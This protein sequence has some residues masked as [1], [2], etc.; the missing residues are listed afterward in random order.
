MTALWI[1]AV[2]VAGGLGFFT[3]GLLT[4]GK[5]EDAYR[6]G[7]RDAIDEQLRRAFSEIDS[8]GGTDD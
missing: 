2:I 8:F 4:S 7:R 6:A 3:A 1:L 5:T